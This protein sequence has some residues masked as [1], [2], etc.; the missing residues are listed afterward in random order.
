MHMQQPNP[1]FTNNI[2]PCTNTTYIVLTDHTFLSGHIPFHC[3]SLEY[4]C[5]RKLYTMVKMYLSLPVTR[6]RKTLYFKKGLPGL[7]N[8][9]V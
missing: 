5:N 1:L 2:M 3:T 9:T 8:T 4:A 6:Y 7:N